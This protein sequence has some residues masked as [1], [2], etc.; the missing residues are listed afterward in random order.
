MCIICPEHGEFWQSPNDHLNGC[1][2]K[3]C[4]NEKRNFIN[5]L[6][7]DEFIERAKLKH[8]NKYDYSKVNYVNS[9]SKVCIICPEHGEFWQMPYSHINGN[10][11]PMCKQSQL[12]RDISLMLSESGIR[13]IYQYYNYEFLNKLSLDF[14]LPD[15]NIGIECQGIQHFEPIEFFG[16]EEALKANKERDERKRLLCEN[17]GIN[18]VYYFNDEKHFGTYKHEVHNI[19]ELKELLK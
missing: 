4:A 7:C 13:Y 10:G 16:G 1:G 3:K 12:E 5:S 9:H 19:K 8:G 18:I 11:C 14:Y 17:N 15:Y 6:T 2:C